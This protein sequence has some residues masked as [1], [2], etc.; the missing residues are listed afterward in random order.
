M[1][2]ANQ[3]S[4]SWRELLSKEIDKPY[5]HQLDSFVESEYL[6]E[7]IFPPRE[8]LFRALNLCPLDSVRVVILGQDPYHNDAQA[9]GLCFSV[10]EGIALPPSLKN[11]YK[12]IS[13]ELGVDPPLSGD[14][15]H[16]AEQGVLMLNA[17]LTVR[18]HQAGSHAK[19]GWEGFTDAIIRKVNERCSG[20]VYMLWGSYAQ[21]K[22][23]LV[24]TSR[25][26]V[27]QSVHPSPLS[28]YRGFFGCGHFAQ[29]NDYLTTAIKWIKE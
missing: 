8:Q 15:S 16:W 13:S 14:L 26:L 7:Q 23:S 5:F 25:N 3:L 2:I 27:L 19:K 4:S 6:N 18:A 9:N 12:E 17:V 11:I 1:S 21:K 22:C 24:D 10:S 28:C 29:A 20:V